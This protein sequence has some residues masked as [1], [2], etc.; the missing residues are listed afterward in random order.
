QVDFDTASRIESR[1]FTNLVVNQQAKNMIQ[2][3]F[4]DLQAINS[5]SLRPAGVERWQATK[6]A[7]LGAGMMGAGIAYSCA[8][9]GMQ[10]VLKDVTLEAAERGK[11]YTEKLNAKGVARGKIS[12]EKAD[13]LLGRITPTADA[14]ELAGCDLVI[15]AVF[16]DPSLKAKVFAEVAPYVDADALLCS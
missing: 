9:A 14:A 4:F 15:E 2:A 11:A 12:Q 16:E 8:R 6:V 10:V 1:Y 5:G 7:V 3:F 13:A